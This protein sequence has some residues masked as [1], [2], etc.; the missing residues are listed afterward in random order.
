MKRTR[1]WRRHHRQRVKDRAFHILR[2]QW[3]IP[4]RVPP[5]IKEDEIKEI[6]AKMADNMKVCSSYCCGNPR[7]H[8]N[9]LTVQERRML[10]DY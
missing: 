7:K 6:A 8:F 10:H 1:S 9:E 3:Y 4:A 5:L 2:D